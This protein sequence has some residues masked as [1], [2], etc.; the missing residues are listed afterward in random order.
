[1]I[2]HKRSIF[3]VTPFLVVCCFLILGYWYRNSPEAAVINRKDSTGS[4][5]EAPVRNTE[6]NILR[7]KDY[8]NEIESQKASLKEKADELNIALETKE[9]ELLKLSGENAGLKKR[10]AEAVEEHNKT[11][12][13]LEAQTHILKTEQAELSK[14]KAGLESCGT[15]NDSLNRTILGLKKNLDDKESQRLAVTV[16]LKKLEESHRAM[17]SELNTLKVSKEVNEKHINQLTL[18]IEELGKTNTNMKDS[19]SQLTKL[20]AKKETEISKKRNELSNAKDETGR[21]SRKKDNLRLTSETKDK[22][23]SNL[24]KKLKELEAKLVQADKEATLAKERQLQAIREVDTFKSANASLRQKLLD[25]TI[26]FE[27]LRAERY[28]RMR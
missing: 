25:V 28:F 21:T 2:S 6:K 5:T 26:E 9:K 20:L 13:G 22:T 4:E 18:R 11:K 8:I 12:A 19:V 7:I 17:E 14:V 23:V 16:E 1:M 24:S 27:L 10:L 3:S 15:Q